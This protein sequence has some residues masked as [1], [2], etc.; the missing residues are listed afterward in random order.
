MITAVFYKKKDIV[1]GFE[2]SGHA[3]YSEHGTDI[4]CAAVSACV[5]LLIN[6]V[7]LKYPDVSIDTDER[8]AMVRMI[9][10]PEKAQAPEV[11]NSMSAFE[12]WLR[13]TSNDLLEYINMTTTEVK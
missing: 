5:E 1:C 2:L 9:M 3:D 8:R 7:I 6:T 4:V 13:Q 11:R 10:S 12:L